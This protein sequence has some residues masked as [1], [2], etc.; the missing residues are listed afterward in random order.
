MLGLCDGSAKTC[1]IGKLSNHFAGH[2][3]TMLFGKMAQPFVATECLEN[4]LHVTI[5]IGVLHMCRRLARR[6]QDRGLAPG[7]SFLTANWKRMGDP[8]QPN[9]APGSRFAVAS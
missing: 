3:P 9:L 2:H 8:F 6:V 1:R 4:G 7:S 5:V